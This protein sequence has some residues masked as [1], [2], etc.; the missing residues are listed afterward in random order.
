MHTV[1]KQLLLV[2]A[3][4]TYVIVTRL[5]PHLNNFAPLMAVAIFSGAYMSRRMAIGTALAAAVLSDILLG[6]YTPSV[7]FV[8]WACYALVALSSSQWLKQPKL[9][10]GGLFTVAGSVFFFVATNFAVWAGSGMYAHSLAGLERCF[11]MGVPFFRNSLLG[12]LF[13]TGALFGI[14]ALVSALLHRSLKSSTQPQ[15]TS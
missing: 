11:A 15:H 9:V 12:D 3:L 1:K 5:L 13:Y 10:R 2:A 8:V 7:M 6:F 14:A 4:I